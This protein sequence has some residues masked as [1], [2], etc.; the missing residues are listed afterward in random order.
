MGVEQLS[1]RIQAHLSGEHMTDQDLTQTLS[2]LIADAARQGRP[3]EIRGGMTKSFYGRAVSGDPLDMTPHRGIIDYE[4]TELVL[5]ARAGTPLSEIQQLLQAN[6]QMLPFEPP[7]FGPEA[8][9]GGTVASGLSGPRRPYAG[10]VRD[11]VLGVRMING[12]GEVLHFGGQVMKNVAGYDVSRVMAGSMGTLGVLLE[13]SVKVLPRPAHS[14]TI[15]QP[16]SAIRALD[17]LLGWGNR[18]LPVS[19]ACHL[20]DTLHVRLCGARQG[21]EQAAQVIGGDAMEN[22]E[23]FWE[24]IREQTHPFFQGSGAPLWR[25]SLPPGAPA[26]LVPEQCLLD[27]GGALRWFRSQGPADAIRQATQAQGGH[28]TVFRGHGGRIEPF[29]P[30]APPLLQLHRQ[31]K[32]AFDPHGILNP[33]RLYPEV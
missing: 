21:V 33:G 20:D 10:A 26:D 29:H 28:A 31:L 30:L 14:L 15:V 13:V 12:L 5:T 1:H 9:L 23:A 8:T 2:E 27:W 32:A 7:A 4:P 19:A 24:G 6:G 16:A 3:L 22:A 11:A 25:L 17:S 18:P